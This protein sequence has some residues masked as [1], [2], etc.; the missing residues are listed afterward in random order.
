MHMNERPDIQA[1]EQFYDDFLDRL[2]QDF[3][4]GNE[5]VEAA[6]QF[7]FRCF[8]ADLRRVLDI[9]CG[10]G[11][12]SFEMA[13]AFPGADVTGIDLSRELVQT[14]TRLFGQ[15]NLHFQK[16]DI[17]TDELAYDQPF[18]AITLVD[19]YE[20]IPEERRGDFHAQLDRLLAPEGRLLITCPTV[21]HQD[22]LRQHNPAGLQPID[23][24]VTAADMLALADALGATLTVFEYRSI[25]HRN[26]Y[27]HALIERQPQWEAL[28]RSAGRRTRLTGRIG[29]ALRVAARL[30]RPH[31]L[32]RW[33]V[34]KR[35]VRR[36]LPV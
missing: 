5:R 33:P 32:R 27:F 21:L 35:Y 25:W 16:A 1:V 14:A 12:T 23:E 24:D 10:L 11:W 18:D 28:T 7:A 19:V 34:L 31:P 6:L 20:H 8:P 3:L 2:L 26:D 15:A 13:R 22:W 36:F 30:G 29:R 4:V 17:F 9:G